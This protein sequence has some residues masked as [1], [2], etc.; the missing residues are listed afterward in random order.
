MVLVFCLFIFICKRERKFFNELLVGL[1][2]VVAAAGVVPATGVSEAAGVVA[3][4]ELEVVDTVCQIR[5]EFYY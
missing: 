3:A 1:L 2:E 4:L 5:K